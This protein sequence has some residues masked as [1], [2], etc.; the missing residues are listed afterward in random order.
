MS[1]K[2]FQLKSLSPT[3][4]GSSFGDVGSVVSMSDSLAASSPGYDARSEVGEDLSLMTQQHLQVKRF[5]SQDGSSR[6]KTKRDTTSMSMNTTSPVVSINYSLQN[7]LG[8][9]DLAS[10]TL[11]SVK[12][13]KTEVSHSLLS[14]WSS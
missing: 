13:Q 11:S 10:P 14:F 4:L 3:T 7:C 6:K 2:L 12:R 9:A 1:L 8:T 5:L